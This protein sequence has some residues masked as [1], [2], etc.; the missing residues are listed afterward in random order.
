M[1]KKIF[2]LDGSSLVEIRRLWSIDQYVVSEHFMRLDTSTLNMRFGGGV[3]KTFAKRYADRVL[4]LDTVVYGA[5]VDG[6]L[7]G[8]GEIRS[9]PDAK[10]L[11]AEA[12]FTIEAPFQNK[13]I[14]SALL[15]QLVVAAQVR[16]VKLLYMVWLPN[17]EKMQHI[18]L[19]HSAKLRFQPLQTEATIYPRWPKC[20]TIIKELFDEAI[21]YVNYSRHW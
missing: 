17:N 14:G 15:E 11:S 5:F 18:A 7:R 3:S 10:Q 6:E 4:A 2:K 9:L 20:S 8:L 16:R 21:G 12:A 13:G 19:K 1:S